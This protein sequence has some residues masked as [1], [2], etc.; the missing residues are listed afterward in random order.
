MRI[1]NQMVLQ[2]LMNASQVVAK[3]GLSPEQK[4]LIGKMIEGQIVKAD[5]A[6]LTL[7]SDGVELSLQNQTNQPLEKGDWITAEIIDIKEGSLVVNIKSET[8]NE[9]DQKLAG[10]LT[11]LNLTASE[12][13]IKLVDALVKNSIPVT[14]ENVALMKQSMLE[15]K[16]L[17]GEFEKLSPPQKTWVLE[18]METPVKTLVMQLIEQPA[19]KSILLKYLLIRSQAKAI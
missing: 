14:K 12:D 13:H 8:L 18:N 11:K 10:L 19:P 4:A 17:L 3:S 7:N 1:T 6:F 16:S 15:V 9:S 2:N 5:G